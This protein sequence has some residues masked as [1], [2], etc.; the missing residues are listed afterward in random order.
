MDMIWHNNVFI[1]F[2]AIIYCLYLF[3]FGLNDLSDVSKNYLRATN[4]RPYARAVPYGILLY[5]CI[6]DNL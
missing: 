2:Y 6:S 1:Y 3:Y 5:G 4:G